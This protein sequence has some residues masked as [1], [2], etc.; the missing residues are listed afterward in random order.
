MD[1]LEQLKRENELQRQIIAAQRETIEALKQVPRVEYG[2]QPYPVWPDWTYWPPQPIDWWNRQPITICG[3]NTS[4][5]SSA[6]TS[7]KAWSVN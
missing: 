4:S 7:V 5:I 3:D 1:E 2:P 6:T